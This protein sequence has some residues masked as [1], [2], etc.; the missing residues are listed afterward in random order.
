[1]A[2]ARDDQAEVIRLGR[3]E[4]RPREFVA[5]VD[6]RALELTVR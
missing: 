5:A 6:G 2:T 4:V 1:M 3:L